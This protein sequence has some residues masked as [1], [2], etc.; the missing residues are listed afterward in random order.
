[1]TTPCRGRSRPP[2]CKQ[3]IPA[4][5]ALAEGI[6]DR[7]VRN[8][9]HDRRLARQQRPRGRLSGGGA[10][11]GR[12]GADQ[13]AQDRRRRFL[14][15]HVRDGARRRRDHH[16]GELPGAE[17]GGVREVSESGVALRAGRRVRRADRQPACASPSPA[18]IAR[19]SR[20]GDRGRAGEEL[21]RRCRQGGEDS[22]R[23]R[24]TTTCT[25]RPNI[26]RTWSRC[27]RARAVAAAG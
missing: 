19:A 8:R 13:Q 22:R 26:A 10:R 12:D 21:H 4:L 7:Q 3:A 14:Q 25:A 16:R 2:T 20:E 9:G 6:G 15:G 27:W 18:R 5:A 1:M 17:E 23:L 11:P 24:S